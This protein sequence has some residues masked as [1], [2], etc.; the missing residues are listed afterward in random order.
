MHHPIKSRI[1]GGSEEDTFPVR[2][3]MNTRSTLRQLFE[4]AGFQEAAFAKLDDLTAFGRFRLLNI[5]ELVAWKALNRL[6]IPYAENC[7]L[8]VYERR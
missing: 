8:G 7:L 6:G 5:A 3:L 1:W 2:Y 4:Q